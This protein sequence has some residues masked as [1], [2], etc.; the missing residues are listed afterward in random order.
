MDP[1][2]VQ[3]ITI[4]YFSGTR[5]HLLIHRLIGHQP[6]DTR[7][8]Q[9]QEVLSPVGKRCIGANPFHNTRSIS[10]SINIVQLRSYHL[11]YVPIGGGTS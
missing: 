3:H 2:F 1:I 5:S 8:E 11:H 6:L 7:M 10:E 9:L 4:R